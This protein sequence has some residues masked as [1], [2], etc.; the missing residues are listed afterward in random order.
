[1]TRIAIATCIDQPAITSD[2]ELLG[3]ALTSVGISWSA[4]PWN[5][6]E[7]DWT[8]FDGVL[9]RSTWD[10]HQHFD[11]FLEWIM[12]IETSG[13]P[14]W[15]E[16]GILRWSLNKTY[17]RDLAAADIPVVPT[18]WVERGTKTVDL[19][20][21]MEANRWTEVV[22]KPAVSAGGRGL[23]RYNRQSV[24]LAGSEV[25]KAARWS[26]LL[27]QPFL[28]EIEQGELSFVLIGGAIS[29]VVRKTPQRG[30]Y[31][32]QAKFGGSVDLV[33]TTRSMVNQASLAASLK[34]EPL[35]ARVD[36]LEIDGQ[37]I[38]MEVELVEPDLFF[39]LAPTAALQ[40]AATLR[41]VNA[42]TGEMRFEGRSGRTI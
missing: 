40:F 31:R 6:D 38:V 33:T 3:Q 13:I 42:N 12:H 41:R 37:L 29:H 34:G 14:L 20:Q 11:A 16:P 26:D 23:M 9:I 18:C 39:H 19:L 21:I 5:G 4:V 27:I 17:L 15:N 2:D 28:P 35:Y 1:M 8:R 30:D 7:A 22:V 10:Y 25:P 36:G 24:A 32:V